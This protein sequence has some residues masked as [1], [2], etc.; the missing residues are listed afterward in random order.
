M[1]SSSRRAP[2]AVP[3]IRSSQSTS[4]TPSDERQPPH[5]AHPFANATGLIQVIR[6]DNIDMDEEA[7]FLQEFYEVRSHLL[8]VHS[9]MA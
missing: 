9:P 8:C 7:R 6:D 2:S 5:T 3:P 1:S 4:M